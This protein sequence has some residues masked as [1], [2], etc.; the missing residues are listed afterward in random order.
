MANRESEAASRRRF[1]AAVLGA[2]LLALACLAGSVLLRSREDPG[3]L[4][5]DGWTAVLAWPHLALTG[6]AIALGVVAAYGWLAEPTQGPK[7]AYVLRW[8]V[9]PWAVFGVLSGVQRAMLSAH[10]RASELS[11]G[12]VALHVVPAVLILSA[13]GWLLGNVMW[14]RRSD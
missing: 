2:C 10:F 3:F 14:K 7:R 9:A 1:N 6:L 13:A 11:A 5:R 4:G 12:R 8:G